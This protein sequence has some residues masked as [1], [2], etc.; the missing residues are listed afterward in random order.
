MSAHAHRKSFLKFNITIT[1]ETGFAQTFPL[2]ITQHNKMSVSGRELQDR[3]ES[4]L[5]YRVSLF[6]YLAT[7]T[8]EKTVIDIFSCHKFADKNGIVYR[9][10]S[11]KDLICTRLSRNE[12]VLLAHNQIPWIVAIIETMNEEI[13]SRVSS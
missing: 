13:F 6:Q 11:V 8:N 5:G 1:S 7:T 3:V 2:L 4:I 10:S 12:N 9:P